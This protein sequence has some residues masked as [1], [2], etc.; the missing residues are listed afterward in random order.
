[1]VLKNGLIGV[2]GHKSYRTYTE[3]NEI[4]YYNLENKEC[5][6]VDLDGD[7]ANE[8]MI[9]ILD[10]NKGSGC[11]CVLQVNPEISAT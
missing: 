11:L 8:Y 4:T 7:K 2:I 3:D 6:E 9:Y 1:M 10:N 5:I